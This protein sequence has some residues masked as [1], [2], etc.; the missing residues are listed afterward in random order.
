LFPR[1]FG[2]RN[3]APLW[4]APSLDRCL[5]LALVYP[6]VTI[7]VIWAV[8][9]HVGP[10]EAA[11]NLSAGVENWRRGLVVAGFVSGALLMARALRGARW[12]ALSWWAVSLAAGLAAAMAAHSK[13]F[14]TVTISVVCGAV[15]A[16][17]ARPRR[18]AGGGA[19]GFFVVMLVAPILAFVQNSALHFTYIV[20][21]IFVAVAVIYCTK[22]LSLDAILKLLF[23]GAIPGLLGAASFFPSLGAWNS[24]GPVLLFVGLFTLMNAPFDWVSLGLTRALLRRGLELGGWWPYV[25]ALADA[26][27]AVVVIALLA[28][29]MV[30]GV[31][32][33]DTVAVHAGGT[34]VLPLGPLL[35]GLAEHPKAPEYWWVYALLL[36]TVLPSLF[37]LVIGGTA[38]VRGVPGVGPL[39]LQNM[40]EGAEVPSFDRTWMS[41][42]LTLQVFVGAAL[43]IA[44]QGILVVVMIG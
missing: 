36:S 14:D 31:Q 13:K 2:L 32:A 21:C 44:A 17:F 5:L 12:D 22:Y 24:I 6:I 23:L 33:F 1:A 25:L 35:A 27:A 38:L 28:I 11:L 8:S 7:W 16:E 34:P 39:L 41:V 19:I 37:N 20:S 10:A 43:G 18:I 40:P 29:A 42:L 3:P 30:V 9:G 26:A 15:A 4:T